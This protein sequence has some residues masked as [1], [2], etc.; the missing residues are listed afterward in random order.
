MQKVHVVFD[1]KRTLE[2]SGVGAVEILIPLNRKQKRY[3]TVKKCS[4]KE[5]KEFSKSKELK[6]EIEKYEKVLA[7]MQVLNE[8][9]TLDNLNQYLGV[10][11]K[12]PKK[13]ALAPDEIVYSKFTDF[14][15]DRLAE[16]K[17]REGTRKQKMV[18]LDA[19][20]NFKKIKTFGDLTPDNLKLFDKW[21]RED[22]TRQDACIHNYHKNLRVFCRMAL[23]EGYIDVNPYD[24]VSFP[25]GKSPERHPL[26]EEELMSLRDADLEGHVAR[27]RDLFV[28]SA[29]C[30]LAFCDAM[31]FNFKKMTVKHGA[32]YYIDG[33]RLKTGSRFY[34]PIMPDGMEVLRRYDYQL[35]Q[36][37]NQKVNDYLKVAA[38]VAGIT[39]NV[40]F[41]LARHTFATMMLT[42]NVPMDKVARML[43]HQ[44]IKTTQ[45]Y[46]KV[47]PKTIEVQAERVLQNGYCRR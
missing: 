23:E 8:E 24:R 25:R 44:D 43:G 46:A 32:L 36:M 35:P 11:K 22:G 26:T 17:I 40:T 15:R 9:M 14:M 3:V 2:K 19:L 38:T 13:K 10:K 28:F 33:E 4:T 34:A 37:S 12:E 1:R 20:I 29:S 42:Y 5:W 47:L 39:K 45:I 27:A 6:A 41:H 16:M 31:L 21:L 7:S 30:G 18:T